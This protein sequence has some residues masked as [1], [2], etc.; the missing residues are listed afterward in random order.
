MTQPTGHKTFSE[1]IDDLDLPRRLNELADV[2]TK[3]FHSARGVAGD[4]A[5]DNRDKVDG[6]LAKA[7]SAIDQRTDG[8]YHDTVVKVRSSL[9]TGVDKLAAQRPGAPGADDAASHPSDPPRPSDP[10]PGSG[11]TTP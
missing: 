8:K 11:P 9:A 1:R 7:E 4:L 6:L 10:T 2:A 5:H 3:T